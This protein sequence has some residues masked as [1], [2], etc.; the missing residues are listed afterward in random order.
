MGKKQQQTKTKPK[1]SDSKRNELKVLADGILVKSR[2]KAADEYIQFLE[3]Y[4]LLER[5]KKLE[6]E[7]KPPT[8]SLR[9]NESIEKF[10]RW[11]E[12]QGAKFTKVQLKKVSSGYDLGLTA[13][14]SLK[15]E[16]KKK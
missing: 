16:G 2:E 15:K 4:E 5:I 13:K 11:C 12:E 8:K 1:L 10:I 14:Q 3:I 9:D 7:I 6:S